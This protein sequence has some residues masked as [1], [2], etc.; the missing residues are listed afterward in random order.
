MTQRL[1]LYQSTWHILLFMGKRIFIFLVSFVFITDVP[2]YRTFS[3]VFIYSVCLFVVVNILSFLSARDSVLHLFKKDDNTMS[4]NLS[5]MLL[6]VMWVTCI[7]VP[8]LAWID[9]PK[10]V[11]YLHKWEQFQV[12]S[13]WEFVEFSFH[14]KWLNIVTCLISAVRGPK[15]ATTKKYIFTIAMFFIS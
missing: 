3:P 6:I 15:F 10:F 12:G 13:N 9:T 14:W 7:C 4:N 11:Q 8:V 1:V 2:K 5:N